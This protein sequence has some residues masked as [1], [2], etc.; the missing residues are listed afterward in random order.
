MALVTLIYASITSEETEKSEL[1][2]D[3][4]IAILCVLLTIVILIAKSVLMFC[5]TRLFFE[6][7]TIR[8]LDADYKK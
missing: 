8:R 4:D 7:W 1:H 2:V 3:L 6:F 5:I